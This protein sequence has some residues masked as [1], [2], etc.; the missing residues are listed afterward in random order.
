[1][2]ATNQSVSKVIE[3]LVKKDPYNQL[4][5]TNVLSCELRNNTLDVTFPESE[6]LITVFERRKGMLSKE[7]YELCKLKLNHHFSKFHHPFLPY[8]A[9]S[10][11]FNN[12]LLFI[13]SDSYFLIKKP[14]FIEAI[15]V[16]QKPELI[17]CGIIK[18]ST[19]LYGLFDFLQLFFENVVNRLR[20]EWS[21]LHPIFPFI[22]YETMFL[23]KMLIENVF[24]EIENEAGVKDIRRFVGSP[25][26]TTI[27]YEKY[28]RSGY[29]D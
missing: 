4:I 2:N 20:D 5:F 13:F 25:C 14:K 15:R 11:K 23:N 29:E 26:F 7:L 6:I 22:D 1:M 3:L 17:S 16:N 21:Y 19:E 8:P 10:S 28:L 12:Y 27:S 9:V 18:N 24:K